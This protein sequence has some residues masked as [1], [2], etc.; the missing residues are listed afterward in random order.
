[1]SHN[2]G[3]LLLVLL[4]CLFTSVSNNC[5]GQ[6]Q[7]L[8]YNTSLNSTANNNSLYYSPF[9]FQEPCE[10][11]TTPYP[12]FNKILVADSYIV[13]FPNNQ[14][15]VMDSLVYDFCESARNGHP[16][17]NETTCQ[18]ICLDLPS[19][20]FQRYC[21]LCNVVSNEFRMKMWNVS[22]CRGVDRTID[23][24]MAQNP[25]YDQTQLCGNSKSSPFVDSY[26]GNT[27]TIMCYCEE[28][29]LWAT[30]CNLI[31]SKRAF[32]AYHYIVVILAFIVA[33]VSITVSL[34]PSIIQLRIFKVIRNLIVKF[35]TYVRS[36]WTG[37]EE[38]SMGIEKDSD[39]YPEFTWFSVK[40]FTLILKV[41]I[42]LTIIGYAIARAVILGVQDFK[43][44]RLIIAIVYY[45]I[46]VCVFVVTLL[47]VNLAFSEKRKQLTDPKLLI[48]LRV[49]L[50]VGLGFFLSVAISYIITS[51]L[52][53]V[54]GTGIIL[55]IFITILIVL[56]LAIFGFGMKLFLDLTRTKNAQEKIDSF[57]SLKFTRFIMLITIS[58]IVLCI[59]LILI[60]VENIQFNTE[61]TSFSMGDGS[62]A[63]EFISE[64]ILIWILLL[65]TLYLLN[66]K[67]VL[68]V[69]EFIYWP[70]CSCFNRK[71]KK[72]TQ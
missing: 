69:Y 8:Y 35:N 64:L 22:E 36:L 55:L 27:T 11:N 12:C 65:L 26:R 52:N 54:L 38:G 24:I 68:D 6:E 10:N 46:T 63:L 39:I 33:F 13:P 43:R 62:L 60:S 47:W 9:I 53:E 58:F 48:P 14:Q 3:I 30:N 57:K 34:I 31:H 21:M 71:K 19:Y 2:L 37:S 59:F 56:S 40:H 25:D 4:F 16:D 42:S 44:T 51:S 7:Q 49:L 23:I 29:N 18:E 32:Y 66:M 70:F 72:S 50:F 61:S 45:L 67:S 5:L 41:M 28:E 17:W 15:V 1:M 20:V